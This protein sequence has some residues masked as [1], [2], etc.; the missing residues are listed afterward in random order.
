M[1]N[2]SRLLRVLPSSEEDVGNLDAPKGTPSWARAMRIELRHMWQNGTAQLQRF[3]NYLSLMEREKGYQ[4]LDDAFGHPFPSLRAFCLADPPHGIGFAPNVLEAL[5]AETRQL[6]IGEFVAGVQALQSHGGDH[7]SEDF[8]GSHDCLEKS[9]RGSKYR[10]AKLKRDHPGIAEA[11]ARG[12]YPSVRAAAKA[13]G[14]VH[15]LTPLDYLHRYWRKVSPDDR[16]RFLIEML[17]P[18]ERRALTL[19]FEEE[20][21]C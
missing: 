6:T 4:Q 16:L 18:N 7:K 15:D 20:N 3:Q 8:Q 14:F 2:S 11:L 13:A 5:V 9:G 1:K 21:G 10:I 19:G 12:E 17:T